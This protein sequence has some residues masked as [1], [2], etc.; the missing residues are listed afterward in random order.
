MSVLAIILII[1]ALLAFGVLGAVVEGLLWLTAIA[2][3]VFVIGAAVGYFRFRSS[4]AA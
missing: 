1:L 2:V 3:V 4:R